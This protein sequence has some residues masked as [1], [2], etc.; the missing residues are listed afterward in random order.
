MHL[1]IEENQRKQASPLISASWCLGGGDGEASAR[2][3]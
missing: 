2:V 3:G 1:E